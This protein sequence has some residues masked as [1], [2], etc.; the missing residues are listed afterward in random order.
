M[1]YIYSFWLCDSWLRWSLKVSGVLMCVWL[2]RI[3]DICLPNICSAGLGS[4][5]SICF[6]TVLKDGNHQSHELFAMT[7]LS[8][9]I[10]LQYLS[11]T[12]SIF[13]SISIL[14][15]FSQYIK[16]YMLYHYHMLQTVDILYPAK[17]TYLLIIFNSFVL[18][19]TL[20]CGWDIWCQN[21]YQCDHLLKLQHT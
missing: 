6:N 14:L 13:L 16:L 12:I 18:G 9:S 17:V 2:G 5:D 4:T 11:F 21:I 1:N 10:F 7:F 3:V 15:L 20:L 8:I 19:N